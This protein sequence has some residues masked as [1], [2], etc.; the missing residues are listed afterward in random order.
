M[1]ISYDVWKY[2]AMCYPLETMCRQWMG[3]NCGGIL[4]VRGWEGD[5]VSVKETDRE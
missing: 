5:A 2:K 4:K 1:S 3:D